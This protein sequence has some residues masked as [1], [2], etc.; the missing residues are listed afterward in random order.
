MSTVCILLGLLL[1]SVATWATEPADL[2]LLNV[3]PP[4]DPSICPLAKPEPDECKFDSP[5]PSGKKCCC[6]NCGWKCVTPVQVRPGR[7]PPIKAKCLMPLPEPKCQ[8]DSDCLGKKKCCNICGNSC[9]DPAEEPHGVCPVSEIEKGKSLVCPSVLCSQ[10]SD[11]AADEKCCVSGDGQKCVKPSSDLDLLNV[12]PP[13]DPSI[14]PL[15]KPGPDDCK[16]DSP[17]PSGKKCCCSNCGWKCVPPV[18]VRP[19]RCPPIKAKCLMPLP[20]PKCQTDSDCPGKQKCC[21]ICGN[22]CWDP[23]E[24]PHGVCPVSEIKKGKSLVCPSVLC[25]R[26]SDCAADEKCCVSGDGQK[27]VKPSSDLD[28]LNVCPPFDPSICPLAK[29][30]PDDCKF[31]SPC[32]SGKKCCCS[33]CGWKCVPPVQ[34]KPGRCPPIVVRCKFPPPEPTCQADRDCPG[35]QKC[36]NICGNSCWNPA[37]EPHGVCPVGETKKRKSLVCPSVL[38]SRDSDCAADEKCCVSGDGQKCVKPSPDLELLNVC[39]PFDPSICPLAKPGP[40]DCKF[41]GPCP[42][43]KKCCC[44]NCGWK[45][46]TPVQVRPGRCPPI[47]AKCLLPLP[48]PKCQ[49]D[50]DCPGKQK[51]CNICGNSCW[52]PAEEPHGVCPVS[53]IKK[54]KSLVCPSVLCSR[55][56]DCAADEKCCVSGDGQK[57]V[58]PSSDLDLLNVCPPFDPSI[59]PLAKPGPDDCKF[60][61]PCPSGKK[62]CCSNCGWKCVPPGQ[63]RPGRCPPIVVRCKFPPPEPTCQADRDCPGKQKCCNICGNSCWNPAEEP[64]GVC[65]VGETKKRKSLVCLSVL[66]SRDSDCAA[67][68]KCCVSGDGQ[69]C[70]KPSPDLDLLNVCPPFD[71]SICPLAKPGPDDCKF[72]SPCPS[73]KKCCCSNCGWKCVTPVQVRPGRC[74]PIKAKCLLPLP[75]PKCQTDSDCPGKQKCCNI[76]GNSCWDPAE[77]PHGVCPVSEIK[78][79]KSLVCPSVLC[80]RDSDCAADEK[81]CVSGDG[82][83][84]V[85]PSSDLDLLNVCPPF[86]P[87]ICP[88]AKPGP[89]DCKFDSPCPSGKKCCCSNCGWKCVPPVQVRPGRCPPIVVRCKFPPPEPTCQADR[90]CPGKQKCCNICGNSCW[91]PAEEPHGVCPVGETEKRKSLVCPSV[92]CSRDSD[93]AA[94]EKC[95]VSGDGQKCVKPSPGGADL[96]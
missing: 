4:F 8:T 72:D 10:D 50:S 54:G 64:H 25:S 76:C 42:S 78:K 91:D 35:K 67:D 53:E 11:C 89:D 84:C 94:D 47:K 93:C 26:D 88:L 80:S 60:D 39:P 30:G 44:S 17:C 73:G 57:C 69:K 56:S 27:C 41:D 75:K 16:F 81:C 34:V 40:D 68:E 20:E 18:Q 62:C 51:C 31:D 9:W 5:C 32:P 21:N 2:D 87:S 63:V 65:P 38:C 46:V 19:G 79:G 29:P 58:K 43:G 37:E 13:F 96:V 36:C 33:N 12:C 49:T 70:V 61:S 52:D 86:D 90:D 59:C 3:C 71:P 22:S 92:L 28:L 24:E 77:E 55:D 74:P 85:K 1:Y 48:K 66:C 83:K 23:A 6:S 7:C 15:A 14:C 82:Q 95:C 45:C